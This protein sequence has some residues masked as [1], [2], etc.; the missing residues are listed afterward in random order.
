MNIY[1]FPLIHK[2]YNPY[3]NKVRYTFCSKRL[4]DLILKKSNKGKWVFQYFKMLPTYA[5]K[6]YVAK[7][8]SSRGLILLTTEKKQTKWYQ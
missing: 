8:V 4:V 6:G 1:R 7:A 2:S 3:G 5:F